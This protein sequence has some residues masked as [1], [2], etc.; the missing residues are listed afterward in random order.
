MSENFQSVQERY[1]SELLGIDEATERFFGATVSPFS[2]R[3]WISK[4]VGRPAVK[5]NAIRIGGRYFLR[6]VDVDE[7]IR[8]Q[9]NPELYRRQQA[10]ART[11]KAKR[12]LQKAGA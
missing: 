1:S 9:A 8:A 10:T 5:L 4:G 12:R 7:F 2:V 6:P 3:R 11:E